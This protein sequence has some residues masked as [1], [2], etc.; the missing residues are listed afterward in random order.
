MTTEVEKAQAFQFLRVIIEL[1]SMIH[2]RL[3]TREQVRETSRRLPK[4]TLCMPG[5]ALWF[6]GVNCATAGLPVHR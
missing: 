3:S 4:G 6:Q 1:D 2:A 5:C